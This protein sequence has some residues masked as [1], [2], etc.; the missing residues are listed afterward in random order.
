MRPS[1]HPRTEKETA[2]C[3]ERP[4]E[5]NLPRLLMIILLELFS[6]L[7]SLRSETTRVMAHL[8][9]QIQEQEKLTQHARTILSFIQRIKVQLI[10]VRPTITDDAS[11]ILRGRLLSFP[12]T[13]SLSLEQC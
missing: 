6:L 8:E 5:V 3:S 2:G 10:E 12:P 7:H 13:L 9:E 11:R 4:T 1:D